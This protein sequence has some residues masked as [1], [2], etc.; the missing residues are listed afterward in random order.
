MA[1]ALFRRQCSNCLRVCMYLSSLPSF[2]P[3]L[4]FP[5]G[6]KPVVIDFM[7]PWC[8]KCRMIAPFVDELAEKHQ[9]LVSS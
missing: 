8:G 1:Q 6:D 9:D 7:A 2:M 5:A 3:A 4:S